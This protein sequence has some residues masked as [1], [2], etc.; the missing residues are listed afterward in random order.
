MTTEQNST[1]NIKPLH[2]D[3]RFAAQVEGLD[4]AAGISDADVA[5]IERAMDEHAVLVFRK[6]RFTPAEQIAFTQRFGPLEYGFN[7]MLNQSKTRLQHIEIADISNV[8]DDGEVADRHHRRI[9]NNMANQLWHSDVSFQD[10]PARYSML[11]S[12]MNPSWGGQTE[13]ADMR[14]GF[15]ALDE[16]LKTHIDGLLAEHFSMHSRFMLGDN[17]YT[18]EQI[19][20]IPKAH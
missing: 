15:D 1:L 20:A 19:D 14:A 4:L 3:S 6:Q 17:Q 16:R 11:Y 9:I 10:P 5:A 2:H 13:F 18:Q 8:T 12:V 7:K